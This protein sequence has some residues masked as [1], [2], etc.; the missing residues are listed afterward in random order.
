MSGSDKK[1]QTEDHYDKF[2]YNCPSTRRGCIVFRSGGEGNGR[3]GGFRVN[4][5]LEKIY[6]HIMRIC[7]FTKEKHGT[8]ESIFT[9]NSD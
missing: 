8:T 2:I 9:D 5:L 6:V 4:P 3:A 7:C 1:L